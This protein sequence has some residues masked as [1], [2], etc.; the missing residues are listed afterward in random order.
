MTTILQHYNIFTFLY[1][2]LCLGSSQL[3]QAVE[4]TGKTYDDIGEMIADQV[5]KK[6]DEIKP[7]L[8]LAELCNCGGLVTSWLVGSTLGQ[9]VRVQALAGDTVLCSCARH[10][11]L[12]VSLSTQEYKWVLANCWG[13]LS[14]CGE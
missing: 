13:N 3:T 6:N 2:Y 8:W 5:C 11:T 4:H 7:L 9:A 12:S 1:V 10:L 14:N